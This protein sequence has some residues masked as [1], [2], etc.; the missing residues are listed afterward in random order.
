MRSVRKALL[1]LALAIGALAPPTA[2]GQGNDAY[3]R[4]QE[5]EE[6]EKYPEAAAAYRAALAQS[7][8]SLPALLGLERVYAQLGRSDSLLPILEKAIAAQPRVAA[9]RAAELRTLRSLGDQDRARA[10]FE[11]WRHDVPHDPA[12]YREYARMLIQDG[13]TQAADSVLRQAQA[14]IGSG[15]GFEYELAQLRAAMGL[16]APAARS[17]REALDDNPYLDQAAAFSL[18]VA[19]PAAHADI[20]RVL[21]APPARLGA[22]K[23]LAALE[24]GWGSPRDGWE[25][26]RTFAP[27]T[28]VVAAWLQFAQ[29]AEVA[30]AWLVASS[31][32]SAVMAHRPSP[33]LAARAATA[34][35]NGG[36]ARSAVALAASAEAK[37][38]SSTAAVSV[39]PVHLRGLSALGRPEE[40]ERLLAAYASR[41]QPEQRPRLARLLAWGWIRAGNLTKAREL[42]GDAG[43]AGDPVA[44]GW[45][46]LYDGDLATARKR[47]R[48]GGDASPDLLSALALLSR[49]RAESSPTMGRA[50]LSL[51]R[52]DTLSAAASFEEAAKTLTDAAPLLLATAA[53][54]YAARRSDA[55][56]VALWRSITEGSPDSPEAPEAELEW[57]RSLRRGGRNAEAIQRL[58]HL[59]LTYPQS[60]L[61]PQARRELELAR[62]AVPSTS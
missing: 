58:E 29:R 20:R 42:L 11:R 49:T 53:R 38:D 60:A 46:A 13:L 25:A 40:G 6:Q 9:L 26:L 15:R 50:F 57:A 45:L 5:L 16:W 39:L 43:D 14:D 10:A 7:P 33:E 28:A 48:P 1:A 3:F 55:K 44:A 62:R 31:A 37:L 23:V 51:A 2:A 59:I 32:L 30:D 8:T 56:A 52:G 21:L 22:R 12:P 4:A 19:P 47:L 36:D 61:L 54:L 41:I 17:W 18:M 24:L 27:D 34:A 35:L